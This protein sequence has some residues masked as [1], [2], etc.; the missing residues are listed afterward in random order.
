MEKVIKELKE[1]NKTLFA[2]KQFIIAQAQLT[3]Q[4]NLELQRQGR[5]LKSIKSKME[6]KNGSKH[7]WKIFGRR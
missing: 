4:Q 7:R 2:I 5:H 6:E 3:K 1:M